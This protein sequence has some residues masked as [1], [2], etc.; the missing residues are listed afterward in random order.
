MAPLRLIHVPK[1]NTVTKVDAP[2][3]ISYKGGTVPIVVTGRPG[4]RYIL[5]FDR[6][7]SLT[8]NLNF[9]AAAVDGVLE[10]PNYNFAKEEFTDFGNLTYSPAGL[11]DKLI[12]NTFVL[13]STG[14]RTHSAKLKRVASS[15]RFDVTIQPVT[16]KGIT[17]KLS[18]NAPNKAGIVSIIQVGLNTLTITPITHDNASNFGT[19]PSS[20]A[21][22]KPERFKND[23]YVT[24]AQ[25]RVVY[26]GGTS[27]VSS[28]RLVMQTDNAR[29]VQGMLLSGDGI[30]HGTTVASVNFASITLSAAVTVV[31]G[32]DI[33]FHTV[34]ANIVP[35]SFTITPAA[36]KV[37][38]V[39]DYIADPIYS[40]NN[41]RPLT[42][43]GTNINDQTRTASTLT[44]SATVNL[45]NSIGI[46]SGVGFQSTLAVDGMRNQP[47]LHGTR[48]IIP[49]MQV[50]FNGSPVTDSNDI[51]V[52]VDSIT[53]MNTLVLSSAVTIKTTAPNLI[54]KPM[55]PDLSTF[56]LN[57]DKVGN[58][59]VVSGYLKVKSIKNT[60]T[61]PVYLDSI[62]QVHN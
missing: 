14:K 41:K 47:T 25:D 16:K 62:I 58:N 4:T 20:I 46:Y 6:K 40:S 27:N 9:A 60:S 55:N 61:I 56:G 10:F 38:S 51:A 1:I 12:S 39:M 36:G 54:F 26:K 50:Y 11:R 15:R 19:L 45:L 44:A 7:A 28:T 42:V 3:N 2:A 35:F 43:G 53:D 23:P 49:G 5:N 37:L 33:S 48:N 21:F 8:S 30:P 52:T 24:A 29:V 31:D 32:T 57:I 22:S 34:D 13:G 59:I 17:S 18:S